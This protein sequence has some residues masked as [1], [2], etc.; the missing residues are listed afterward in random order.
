MKSAATGFVA[1]DI[2]KVFN[3]AL[4]VS[5]YMRRREVLT[6]IRECV[7]SV[8]KK[9]ANSWDRVQ[10][11]QTAGV[12]IRLSVLTWIKEDSSMSWIHKSGITPFVGRSQARVDVVRAVEEAVNRAVTSGAIS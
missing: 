2:T 10:E 7:E 4:S 8:V 11:K 12:L 6:L 3:P 9:Y 5:S 1:L